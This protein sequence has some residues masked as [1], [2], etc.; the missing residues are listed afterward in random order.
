MRCVVLLHVK[1]LDEG[2]ACGCRNQPV[3]TMLPTNT[4]YL[5]DDREVGCRGVRALDIPHVEAIAADRGDDIWQRWMAL[6]LV[7][8]SGATGVDF[9]TETWH[10]LLFDLLVLPLS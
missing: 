9:P 5:V 1:Y 3:L 7:H 8:L 2:I 4:M 6:Y 10:L